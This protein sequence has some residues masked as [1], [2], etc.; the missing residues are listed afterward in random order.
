[1]AV[2]AE[3]QVPT[4]R[5]WNWTDWRIMAP[6]GGLAALLV[7]A[8]I[9]LNPATR[10]GNGGDQNSGA[11]IDSSVAVEL[12]P[13]TDDPSLSLL[14]D[15]TSDLDWDAATEAG[16]SLKAGAVDDLVTALNDEERQELQRLLREELAQ[17]GA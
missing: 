6:L 8:A 1:V 4:S 5:A 9:T 11:A 10:L 14:A 12:S 15:L 7:A 3:G 13:L 16:L 2:A 17:P